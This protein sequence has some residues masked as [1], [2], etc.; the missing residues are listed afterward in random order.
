MGVV[1]IAIVAT[2]FALSASAGAQPGAGPKT[3]HIAYT[4]MWDGQADIYAMNADGS[5]QFNLTH[6]KT[7]GQRADTEPAWSPNGQ[8]VAFQRSFFSRSDASLG[9]RLY[10]VTSKGTNLH[11]LTFSPSVTASD[12]HPAWSPDGRM[13]VFSSDRTGHFELYMVKASGGG[14]E[15]LTFT[16]E[17]VDNLDPAWSP[18]GTAIAFV[19]NVGG[20]ITSPT[21]SIYSQSLTTGK[22]YRLT[23]PPPG[24]TDDQPA[25]SSDSA[26]VAFQSDR[27]GNEDI[28]VV[29][30][31]GNS[32]MRATT[33]KYNEV[34]PTWAPGGRQIALISDRTGATEIYTLTAPST[35]TAT[36]AMK[37]LTFDKAAKANPA[38]ERTIVPGP[39]S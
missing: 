33:S 2:A 31:K 35:N 22:T 8:W 32:L 25:W 4:S 37:Q 16:S 1:V 10:L 38:W 36:G 17:A 26:R 28:Y 14:L 15:Q 3:V 5:A 30:Q 6:D 27:A 12:R 13:I 7:V 18:D 23:T 19:R 11:A 39:Q 21:S 20:P 24:K 9:S 29:D 34:H